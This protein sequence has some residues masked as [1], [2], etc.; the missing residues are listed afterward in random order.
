MTQNGCL[1]YDCLSGTDT[2][3]GGSGDPGF[4]CIPDAFNPPSPC[5]MPEGMHGGEHGGEHGG[6]MTP[7]ANG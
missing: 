3:T 2:G 6:M 4:V 1:Y 5:A 7:D